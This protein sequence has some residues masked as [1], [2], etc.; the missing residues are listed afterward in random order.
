M[1]E[2]TTGWLHDVVVVMHTRN[3]VPGYAATQNKD[4]YSDY[5]QTEDDSM[6]IPQK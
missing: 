6:E 4:H 1:S 5:T 2:S 3:E